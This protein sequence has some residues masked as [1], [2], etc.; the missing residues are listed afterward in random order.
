MA[1]ILALQVILSLPQLLSS[2]D[3]AQ[4][5]PQ[6]APEHTRVAVSKTGP[7]LWLR[8][9]TSALDLALLRLSF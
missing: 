3:V 7:T 4:K 2:A 6:T 8:L 9:P 1:N 5:Q